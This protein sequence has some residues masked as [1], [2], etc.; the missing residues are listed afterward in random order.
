[1]KS[2]KALCAAA[3]FA[4]TGSA[5]ATPFTMTSPEGVNVN[6]V[7]ATKIGG[8]VIDLFGKNGAHVVSE[9]SAANL[10]S[11][12]SSANFV[13]GTQTG[14][15]AAV[16]AAL[17]G[18]LQSAAF[19]FT[20]WDGDSAAGEFDYNQTTLWTNG[21]NF[22]NWS[23]V[24]T[25]ET[26]ST[27]N[28][29]LSTSA[30]GFRN[31]KLDTGWFYSNNTSLLG[32]LFT[33]LQS[34]NKLI[35]SMRDSDPGDNVLDFKQGVNGSLINVGQAP[36]VANVPEPGTLALLGLSLLA[37]GAARRKSRKQK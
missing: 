10:Y 37:F 11:G 32:N 20:L 4:A 21:I 24:I 29:N 19:R 28:N 16:L 5:F 13:I 9:V 36:S 3:L 12:T 15:S 27:G 17:G 2:L 23:T 8:I 33:S 22:G 6:G 25:Q 1:M 35:F 30:G 34:T 31:N 26:D 7:G 18:G 14:Y